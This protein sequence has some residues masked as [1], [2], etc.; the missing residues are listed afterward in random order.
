MAQILQAS[1]L[2]L[3]EVEE[4]LRLQQV[5]SPQ[6]FHEWRSYGSDF[7]D[8]EKRWLDQA[9]E[10]FLSLIKYPLHE[11]IVKL[12]ILAPLLSL[13]GLCRPPFL[14]AAEKQIE[15]ALPEHDELIRGRID[16]LIVHQQ[17]WVT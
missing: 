17:L 13:A 7:E 14:P 10:D 2:T 15:I 4:K 5:R 11:E 16:V 6:F 9:R 1:Q 3:H 8:W 12:V